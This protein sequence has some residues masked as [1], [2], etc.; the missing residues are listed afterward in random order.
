MGRGIENSQRVLLEIF[1]AKDSM[2]LCSYS[3]HLT[4]HSLKD[5]LDPHSRDTALPN[6]ANGTCGEESNKDSDVLM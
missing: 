5:L 2:V 3:Q 6:D 4:F 1:S